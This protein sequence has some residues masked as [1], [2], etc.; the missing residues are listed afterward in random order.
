MG[1]WGGRDRLE[2]VTTGVVAVA[3]GDGLR[4]LLLGLGV[5][6]VVAGGQ[7]MNPSTAQILEAVDACVADGVIVLPNNKNIVP[8]AEQVPELTDL[9]V[10]V[11]P[12]SAVVE[13]LGALLAYDSAASLDTNR[14][15]MGE[16][17]GRVRAGEVTQAVRDSMAE[18][19]PIAT[20]DWIAITR[21]GIQ[22]AVK[23]VDRRR[24]C[25]AR[26]PRRRRRRAGHD[27]RG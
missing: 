18:C 25:V 6:Q 8:V 2:R 7:S 16:A 21:D 22:A 1:P 11:V 13:A 19:G 14:A 9:P 12:T 15:A 27:H 4:T 17:A 10:A 20:G 26:R 23:S 5:Q 3:V 24:R